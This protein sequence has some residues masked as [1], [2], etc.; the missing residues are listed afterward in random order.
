[1]RCADE[2]AVWGAAGQAGRTIPCP[3][4]GPAAS[5]YRRRDSNARLSYE[6]VTLR[7]S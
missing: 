2:G 6:I 5:G 1:M 7:R 4:Q 3:H